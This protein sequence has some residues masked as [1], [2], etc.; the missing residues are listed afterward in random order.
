MALSFLNQL[1][2]DNE[3]S[4]SDQCA[5]SVTDDIIELTPAEIKYILRSFNDG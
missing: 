4:E 5:R 1:M 2:Y 3:T